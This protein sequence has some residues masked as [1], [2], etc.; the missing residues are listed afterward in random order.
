MDDRRE[1]TP[2]GSAGPEIDGTSP[3]LAVPRRDLRRR[4]WLPLLGWSLAAL[5]APPLATAAQVVLTLWVLAIPSDEAEAI[6]V[7]SSP[8]AGA[9]VGVACVC[10]LP[11]SFTV[12][13]V[14]G[15]AYFT[16]ACIGLAFFWMGLLALISG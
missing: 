1:I 5:V 2:A 10:R 4:W 9:I 11:L 12:R 15:L 16:A 13:C 14:L 3:L 7:V 8:L 6:L